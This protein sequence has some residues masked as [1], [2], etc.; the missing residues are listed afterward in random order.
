MAKNQSFTISERRFFLRLFDMLVVVGT[1]F[2][3]ASFKGFYYFDL[4]SERLVTWLITLSIYLISFG[5]IFEMYDLKNSN[6]TYRILRSI[7]LTALST[8]I[9]YIFTPYI[10]PELPPS[11]LQIIFL[12]LTIAL[13]L[14]VWRL[15]YISF[16]FSPKYF[17]NLLLIGSTDE[18][19]NL[20]E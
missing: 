16:I 2:I 17:N 11:R 13:P 15:I 19:K 4:S 9:L 18:V 20:K 1:I 14:L 12:F 6:D 3:A 8:N 7:V 5:Q 10:S